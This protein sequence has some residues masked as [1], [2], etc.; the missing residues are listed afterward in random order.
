MHNSPASTSRG[1]WIARLARKV[2]LDVRRDDGR[3]LATLQALAADAPELV[4]DLLIEVARQVDN[5]VVY[6]ITADDC[7]EDTLE[8]VVAREAHARWGRGDQ[9][10]W[11]LWGERAYQRLRNRRRRLRL[12]AA[13]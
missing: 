12:K 8:H 3:H 6:R 7:P 4:V 5:D 11:V 13:S 9:A 10:T 2:V 1:P